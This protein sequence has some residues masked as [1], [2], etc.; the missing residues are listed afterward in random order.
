[1]D[2]PITLLIIISYSDIQNKQR[3]MQAL[4]ELSKFPIA[5]CVI[6]FGEE[7]FDTM[8]DFDDMIGRKFDDF[9]F[10]E[11]YDRMGVRLDMFQKL[12]TQVEDAR[13]LEYL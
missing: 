10:V 8:E 2:K 11:Y 6:G 1:M 9:K 3:Y 5:C 7:S 12:S 4:I 13:L